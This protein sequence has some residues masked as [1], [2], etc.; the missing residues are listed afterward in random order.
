MSDCFE[1]RMGVHVKSEFGCNRTG[2]GVFVVTEMLCILTVLISISWM[3]Y[4][5]GVS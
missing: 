2:G 5:P 3:L 4:Y 1:L